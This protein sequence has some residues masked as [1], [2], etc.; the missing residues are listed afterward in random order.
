MGN[1]NGRMSPQALDL[2]VTKVGRMGTGGVTPWNRDLLTAGCNLRVHDD[3]LWLRLEWLGYSKGLVDSSAV[4]FAHADGRLAPLE[5]EAIKRQAI[6]GA[7]HRMAAAIDAENSQ[8]Q[9][10]AQH[11]GWARPGTPGRSG[12]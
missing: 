6:K 9:N 10:L 4:E 11:G 7:T 2:H 5:L 12:S 8:R 1:E 3:P